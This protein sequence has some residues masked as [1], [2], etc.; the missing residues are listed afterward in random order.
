V[1]GVVVVVWQ[2]LTS[3]LVPDEDRLTLSPKG[4]FLFRKEQL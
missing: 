1:V 4:M 2:S 3:V